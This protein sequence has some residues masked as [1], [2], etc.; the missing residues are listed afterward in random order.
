MPD[1]DPTELRLRNELRAIGAPRVD[2]DALVAAGRRRARRRTVR[3]R[4]VAGAGIA[5][6]AA[7]VVAVAVLTRDPV[8]AVTDAAAVP[9]GPTVAP[10]PPAAPSGEGT[11]WPGGPFDPVDGMGPVPD[12][13]VLPD[14]RADEIYDAEHRLIAA[15]MAEQGFAWGSAV[16]DGGPG[17]L[18]LYLS[19]DE[20]RADGYRYDWAAAGEEFLGSTGGA[21]PETAGMSEAEQDAYGA[22][23]GFGDEGEQVW[24]DTHDGR[25]GTDSGGCMG[26]TRQRLYGSLANHLRYDSL[27][28]AFAGVSDQLRT[29]DSYAEP[30]ADWQSCMRQAGFDVEGADYGATWIRSA[31]AVALSEH[32][33]GQTRFTAETIPQI[34]N[35]D[36]DCQES[37]GLYEVRTR[38]L[39]GIYEEIA[40][41]LG[42]DLDHFVAYEHALYERARQTP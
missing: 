8:D 6:L 39:D 4:A 10:P 25:S 24:I 34:S 2:V 16:L 38:L 19:P 31:G 15:C 40:A 20:L 18:P 14:Y 27:R 37:S 9:P 5:G 41:D 23:L 17:P 11:T 32:G 36:A 26:E 42:V 29:H 35:A 13:T 28:Q 1:L 33:R 21:A 7:A 30:L 12:G 22:A 3:R